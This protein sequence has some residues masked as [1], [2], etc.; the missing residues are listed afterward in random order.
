MSFVLCGV[1]GLLAT[2]LISNSVQMTDVVV[3]VGSCLAMFFFT[4]FPKESEFELDTVIP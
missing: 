2:G 4:I 3:L 1:L